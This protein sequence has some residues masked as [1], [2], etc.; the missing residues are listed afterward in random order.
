MNKPERAWVISDGRAG[1]ENQALGLA[2]ALADLTPLAISVRRIALDW[3]WRDLAPYFSAR[4]GAILLRGGGDVGGGP[5]IV[6]A[7]G[8]QSVPFNVAA[9]RVFDPAPFRVQLQNP[10]RPLTDFDCVVAPHH[11]G[12]SGARLVGM[13]GSP[14]RVSPARIAENAGP[15]GA[16]LPV[17][18]GARHAVL[19]GGPNRLY[20]FDHADQ[21][22]ILER[23]ERLQAADI[24]LIISG[25]RRTPPSLLREVRARVRP[26]RDSVY[27]P[28]TDDAA[29]NPYPGL[30]AHV[31]AVHVTPDSVNML[32][33][34]ARAGIQ[35]HLIALPPRQS[36][37]K[38]QTLINALEKGGHLTPFN[39]NNPDTPAPSPPEP[40]RET[41]RA[42]KI[43]LE[44]WQAFK[45]R[46][47]TKGR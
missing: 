21:H 16:A 36:G 23:I 26:D 13:I 34:S 37:G 32:C 9:R 31:S 19:L 20:A 22:V 24:A 14:N 46:R 2:E 29:I 39:E 33:E 8:R 4:A 7:C 12:L 27:G 35:T 38:F 45:A 44:Q 40:F 43:V 10:R 15:V 28:D 1:I 3:P 42:A 25:S 6:I 5:D 30:Y 41:E 11:D 47:N 17:V 18:A